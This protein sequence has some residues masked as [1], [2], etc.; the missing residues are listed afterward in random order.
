MPTDINTITAWCVIASTIISAL[1]GF[2]IVQTFQ[3]QA[4]VAAEQSKITK[5]EF[6]RSLMEKR[7][8]FFAK[9]YQELP[10]L[11]RIGYRSYRVELELKRGDIFNCRVEIKPRSYDVQLWNCFDI[12]HL[13]IIEGSKLVIDYHINKS[14][15]ENV[16]KMDNSGSDLAIDIKFK[17]Q[18]I[19]NNDY[20]QQIT[21]PLIQE[22]V[23]YPP[24]IEQVWKK[25]A[26][27]KMQP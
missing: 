24:Y 12:K 15:M 8:L 18:D 11:F 27:L 13:G 3:L 26:Q 5:L 19:L 16:L 21:I 25:V 23:S 17:F 2:F 20:I 9:R 22:P 14:T 6:E 4:Q 7:P 10:D 1:T